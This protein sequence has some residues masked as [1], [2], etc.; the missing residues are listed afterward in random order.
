MALISL[1]K[2]TFIPALLS[3]FIKKEYASFS[4]EPKRGSEWNILFKKIY[5]MFFHLASS[6]FSTEVV[7]VGTRTPES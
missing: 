5:E 3:L 2:F 4:E 6:L 7:A 1:R